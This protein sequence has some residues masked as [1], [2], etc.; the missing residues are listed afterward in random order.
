VTITKCVQLPF[1]ACP[2]FR[3]TGFV[4]PRLR[5]PNADPRVGHRTVNRHFAVTH[6]DIPFHTWQIN[7]SC[8]TIENL[9]SVLTY[10][11]NLFMNIYI[12]YHNRST[13]PIKS[14][15]QLVHI[16]IEQVGIIPAFTY[17]IESWLNNCSTIVYWYTMVHKG[18]QWYTM[19]HKGSRRFT[20]VHKGSQRF[21]I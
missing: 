15:K 5:P 7:C 2:E 9:I 20:K 1:V 6:W 16:I 8:R 17:I 18:L 12:S 19:V 11:S 14:L 4:L 10:N 21:T 3:P 13:K